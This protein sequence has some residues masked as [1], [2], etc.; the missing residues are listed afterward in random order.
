MYRLTGIAQDITARKQAEEAFKEADRRKDEFLAT[1]AHKLRNPL[2][3]IRNSVQIM[4]LAGKN[5]EVAEQDRQTIER[6]LQQMVRLVDD[7]LDVSRITR[8]KI[9][10]RKERVALSSVVQS[11]VETS[12]PLIEAS[13]HALTVTLPPQTVWLNA[14]LTRVAQ[15]ISN[16]LNNAAKY[17]EKGG[18]IWLTVKRQGGHV[19]IRVKDT[20][21]GI[22]APMLSKVFD[23]FTQLDRSLERSQGGLGVGLTLVRRLI[24]MHG[25]SIEARSE[26]PGMGSEFIV[27]LPVVLALVGEQPADSSDEPVG[28]TARRRILVVDDNPDSATS[29]AMMLK[30]MGN[31]TQTAYDGL[32]ALDV[33][34]AF[35]PDVI[36][37]DIGMPK[38]NGYDAARRIRAQ[39]WGKNMVLVALT[40]WSQEEDRRKS[41]DAGFDTH[42]VKPVDYAALMNLLAS[43]PPGNET[44]LR[45]LRK[46]N[47]AGFA[48]LIRESLMEIN[49]HTEAGIYLGTAV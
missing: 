10:L 2:A 49:V 6:Q 13:G 33:A 20:G 16:L 30:L 32:E 37:L 26:G 23:L 5:S 8:N 48:R 42:M 1:L 34:A 18:H 22:P 7:L 38:L 39:P 25:G 19:V 3:P 15:V 46:P 35:R 28:S 14:G 11:A 4:K 36:L 43:L 12:R 27:R 45:S 29:L 47:K 31:D 24:E 41:K 9:E 44:V 17:T 40:G 21:I